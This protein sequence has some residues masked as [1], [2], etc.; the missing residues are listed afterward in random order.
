MEHDRV[1][2]EHQSFCEFLKTSRLPP[3]KTRVL[4]SPKMAQ[5]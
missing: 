3:I 2:Y 4:A 1:P 5:P